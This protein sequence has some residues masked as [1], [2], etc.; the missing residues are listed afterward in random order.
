[1][2]SR[3]SSLALSL[4]FVASPAAADGLQKPK[5]VVE[6]V[7]AGIHTGVKKAE[8]PPAGESLWGIFSPVGESGKNPNGGLQRA[9]ACRGGG[10][11]RP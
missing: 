5:T 1:M 11:S 10:R 4:A 2:N 9:E 3:L 7:V 6:T 8:I